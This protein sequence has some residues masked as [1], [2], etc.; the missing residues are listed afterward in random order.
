MTTQKFSAEEKFAAALATMQDM[1]NDLLEKV[2]TAEQGLGHNVANNPGA[3]HARAIQ[4]VHD[5][6]ARWESARDLYKIA[7]GYWGGMYVPPR[8][9]E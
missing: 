4:A 3:D 9:T 2:K 8:K 6:R 5:A 7:A 1:V